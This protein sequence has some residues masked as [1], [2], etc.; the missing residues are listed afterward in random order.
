MMKKKMIEHLTLRLITVVQCVVLFHAGRVGAALCNLSNGSQVEVDVQIRDTESRWRFNKVPSPKQPTARK[1]TLVTATHLSDQVRVTLVAKIIP[2]TPDMLQSTAWR[3]TKN[4]D[5]VQKG[6]F[7]LSTQSQ[8][9]EPGRSLPVTFNE[10]SSIPVTYHVTVGVD[11]NNDQIPDSCLE[12]FDIVVISEAEY[13]D[14][15]ASLDNALNWMYGPT[16]NIVKLFT[17][18]DPT[19]IPFVPDFEIV[20][21][22]V[23]TDTNYLHRLTHNTGADFQGTGLI[24]TAH[25]HYWGWNYQSDM[26]EYVENSTALKNL[27]REVADDTAHVAEV[28]TWFSSHSGTKM[29]LWSP[30]ANMSFNFAVIDGDE[31]DLFTAFHG[32]KIDPNGQVYIKYE[33]LSNG[34]IRPIYASCYATMLDLIDYAYY[35]DDGTESLSIVRKAAECQIGYDRITR[36]NYGGI[37]L[38]KV[39]FEKIY[40]NP[41]FLDDI[42]P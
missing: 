2:E 37:F 31:R 38:V 15:K 3:I 8:Y 14:A 29:F 27:M 36:R 12:A 21:G 9:G 23:S 13:D 7:E 1:N 4:G 6:T 35:D 16:D 28:K 18:V 33:K 24:G 41:N 19:E 39:D 30:S 5:E 34:I 40:T 20:N 32:V 17:G 22:Y 25:V 10:S 11:E 42:M 26:A